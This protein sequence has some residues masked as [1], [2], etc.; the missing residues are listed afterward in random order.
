MAQLDFSSRC[1]CN[2]SLLKFPNLD[3]CFPCFGNLSTQHQSTIPPTQNSV[4]RPFQRLWFGNRHIHICTLISIYMKTPQPHSPIIN[5]RGQFLD[6]SLWP[7]W[8][9]GGIPPSITVWGVIMPHYGWLVLPYVLQ[10]HIYCQVSNIRHTLVGNTAV[11]HSDVVGAS[12]VGTAPTT[13]S[14]ST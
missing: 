8:M 6:Q 12:P 4:I 1:C 14:F 7:C 11:D 5:G 2:I 10:K 9:L 3:I 13:S